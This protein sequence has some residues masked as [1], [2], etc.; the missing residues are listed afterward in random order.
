MRLR[1]TAP[2]PLKGPPAYTVVP[3]TATTRTSSPIAFA[4]QAVAR[5][6][7]ALSAAMKSRAWPAILV[8]NPAAY[9]ID[10]DIAMLATGLSAPGFQAVARPVLAS[11]AAM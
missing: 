6:V 1:V 3:E 5:P 9:T 2:T 7:L 10:P 11:S 4:F 8:N